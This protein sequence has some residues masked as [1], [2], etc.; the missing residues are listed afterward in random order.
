MRGPDGRFAGDRLALRDE[1]LPAGAEPLLGSVMISEALT[2]PLPALTAIREHC[3]A[4]P[5]ALPEA[6]RRLED[7]AKHPV[8]HSDRLLALQRSLRAEIEAIEVRRPD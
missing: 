8:A 5:R 6:V 4:Q 3:A 1:D 7:P 2:T